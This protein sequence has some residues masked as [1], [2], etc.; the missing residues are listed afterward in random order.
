VPFFAY[1]AKQTKS[2]NAAVIALNYPASQQE[3]QGA[4]KGLATYKVKIAY[5]NLDEQIGGNWGIEADK[6][7]IAGVNMV[8]NCM[9]VNSDVALSKA[10]ANYNMQPVQLWLDGYDRSVLAA[11]ATNM[12]NV[13]FLLQHIPFEAA[14]AY[15]SAYPG[16]N[17][18]LHQMVLHGFASDE[19]SDV[20]LMGWE[21]ANTF[22][23]GLRAAGKNPTQA[24]V[25]A[26]INKIKNDVGGPSGGVTAPVNWTVA[27]KGNTTPAC[28]TYVKV[29]GTVFQL[30]FNHGQHPWV[31]F[32]IPPATANLSHP[33][34]PPRGTPGA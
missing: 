7:R 1:A 25:V 4:I 2:T 20:A 16:L 19:F 9:D 10:M 31:C 24:G 28:E 27:H 21:S 8:I 34:A 5:K 29:S 12:K 33:V 26:A 23:M 22:V 14:T 17:L 30:A 15:P 6:M 3:C 18:Y 11:N 32:P 13:Y